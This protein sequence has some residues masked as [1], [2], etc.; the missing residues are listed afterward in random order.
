M[1][2]T[3]KLQNINS[4]VCISFM[5]SFMGG[6]HLIVSNAGLRILLSRGGQYCPYLLVFRY[7][8]KA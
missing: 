3:Q 8:W 2:T 5:K 4:F 7:F 6:D 1:L